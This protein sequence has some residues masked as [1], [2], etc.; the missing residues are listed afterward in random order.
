MIDGD[1]TTCEVAVLPPL[2]T[3]IFFSAGYYTITSPPI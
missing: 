3:S 2:S 1:H